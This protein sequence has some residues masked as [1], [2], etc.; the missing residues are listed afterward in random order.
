MRNS[1]DY[2]L[3]RSQMFD[4]GSERWK[5][6]VNQTIDNINNE[7]SLV[8]DIISVNLPTFEKLT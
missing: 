3:D 2:G 8:E 7:Q 4:I 1:F 6:E 5:K